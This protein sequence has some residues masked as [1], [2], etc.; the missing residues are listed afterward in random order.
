MFFMKC[1]LLITV[2]CLYVMGSLMYVGELTT[3]A[4]VVVMVE[5]LLLPHKVR[6]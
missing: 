5:Y 2:Y 6:S 4:L 1:I 3:K